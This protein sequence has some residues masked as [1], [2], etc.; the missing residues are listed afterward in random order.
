MWALNP[1]QL[2][3]A[4]GLDLVLGDPRGWPHLAKAA[5]G[6]STRYE[7]ML[8]YFGQRSIGA[9]LLFWLAVCGTML[10]AYFILVWYCGRFLGEWGRWVVWF[11]NTAII[12]QSVAARDLARHVCAVIEPLNAGDLPG[13][14]ARLAWI[15]GRDTAELDH[16]AI[17]RAAIESVAEST[18]DGVIAPLFW[19][20]LAGAPGA[21]LYR[22]VNT[23]DSM[24]GHRNERYENFGKV[25]A[26]ADD[27]LNWLPARI[28]AL[29]FW[30]FIP[31]LRWSTLRAEAAQH[32]SPNAGWSEAAMAYALDV[33]LGGG[34]CYD[35]VQLPGPVFNAAGRAPSVPAIVAS[36]S[37]M[38]RASAI[39]FVCAL[40]SALVIKLLSTY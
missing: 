23:L 27:L 20:A 40:T 28:C 26:R 37:W 10:G 39:G 33:R 12:Y 34:N 29:S 32:A 19:A 5:G 11:L 31:G 22:T 14:R 16:E 4:V 25:S 2:V 8:T 35:G 7:R 9:G 6:L 13:A 38:W 30:I 1:A 17:S 21:L 18:S 36:L 3:L 24:V 15:V